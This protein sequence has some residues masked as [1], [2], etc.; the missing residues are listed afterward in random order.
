MDIAKQVA[1]QSPDPRTKVGCIIVS[2]R[3]LEIIVQGHNDFP[4]CLKQSAALWKPPGKYD[5]VLHAEQ[6]AV[7]EAARLGEAIDGGIA[8]VSKFPCGPCIRLLLQAGITALIAPPPDSDEQWAREYD[9]ASK[10]VEEA[11]IR[12]ELMP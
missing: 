1:L 3:N 5:R 2:D 10:L 4:S 9:V 7:A 6:A 12:L 11:G 8:F